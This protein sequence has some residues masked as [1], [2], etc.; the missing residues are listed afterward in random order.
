MK[1]ENET[2]LFEKLDDLM[3]C[4]GETGSDVRYIKVGLQ[5][6]ETLLYG[7]GDAIGMKGKVDR[8]VQTEKKRAWYSRIVGA[9][10]VAMVFERVRYY[11]GL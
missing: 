9:A 7:N 1:P 4:Q 10:L 11:L 6:H 8:L 5:K 3:K 2:R